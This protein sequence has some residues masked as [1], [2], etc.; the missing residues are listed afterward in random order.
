MRKDT[1]PEKK[2]VLRH[3]PPSNTEKAEKY[4]AEVSKKATEFCGGSFN[5][6]KEYQAREETGNSTGVGTGMGVGMGGIMIGGSS[7][8]TSMYNFVE[9]DCGN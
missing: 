5:I 4:K 8:S 7:R 3:S 2:G 9:F 1:S 6:T